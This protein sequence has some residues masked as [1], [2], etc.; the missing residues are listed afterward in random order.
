MLPRTITRSLLRP[1]QQPS[2]TCL[3]YHLRTF[4][5]TYQRLAE[6]G[7]KTDKDRFA[8]RTKIPVQK[9][10]DATKETNEPTAGLSQAATAPIEEG[11]VPGPDPLANAPR[12]YG[13]RVEKF[14]PTVLSRPIGMLYQPEPGQNTGT[15]L[16]SVKQRRDDF[17]NWDKHLRRREEL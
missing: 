13:K 5:T 10:V 8:S 14:E 15:D 11:P 12:S 2:A 4:S 17:V 6:P 3:P 9:H 1:S 16:R 7:L